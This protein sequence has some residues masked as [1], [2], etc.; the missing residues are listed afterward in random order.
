MLA[1]V[2]SFDSL[3]VSDAEKKLYISTLITEEVEK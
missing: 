1:K 3:S 2:S